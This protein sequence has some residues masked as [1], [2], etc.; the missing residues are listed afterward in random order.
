LDSVQKL[1]RLDPFIGWCDGL[2]DGPPAVKAEMVAGK[3]GCHL[4]TAM[5]GDAVEV[6]LIALIAS[7]KAAVKPKAGL[8]G[9][10]GY[11][12]VTLL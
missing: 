5:A 9:P 12:V 2:V 8:Y 3:V 11:K 7:A 6:V 10:V 4:D 1:S